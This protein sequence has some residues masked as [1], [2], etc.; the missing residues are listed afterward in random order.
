MEL[1]NS[2]K[3]DV[4]CGFPYVV[5]ITLYFPLDVVKNLSSSWVCFLFDNAFKIISFVFKLDQWSWFGNSTTWESI[6]IIKNV[7]LQQGYME[8]WLDVQFLW[9]I[10]S[11]VV[12]YWIG[13]GYWHRSNVFRCSLLIDSCQWKVLSYQKNYVSNFKFEYS[14]SSLV[15]LH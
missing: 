14:M 7:R 11:I 3:V 2:F 15:T 8:C 9:Q 12:Y 5:L 13:C 1:L 4:V 6:V 10:N